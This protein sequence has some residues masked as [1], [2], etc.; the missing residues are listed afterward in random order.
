MQQIPR[1]V[2][3]IVR[4][5]DGSLEEARSK[6]LIALVAEHSEPA[7][8][9]IERIAGEHAKILIVSWNAHRKSNVDP[10]LIAKATRRLDLLEKRIDRQLSFLAMRIEE[11]DRHIRSF[12]LPEGR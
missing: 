4:R 3:R 10:I 6:R 5:I 11:A 7:R 12:D 9:H 2:S 1:I 8:H